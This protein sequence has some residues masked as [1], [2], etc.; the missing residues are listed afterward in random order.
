MRAQKFILAL[1]LIAATLGAP[2]EARSA[3]VGPPAETYITLNLHK[4]NIV[5]VLNTLAQRHRCNVVIGPGVSGEVSVNLHRVRLIEALRAV[6]S[7]GGCT[8]TEKGGVNFI[9]KASG[10]P[11]MPTDVRTIRLNYADV[12]EAAT[13]IS[14]ACGSEVK[15]HKQTRTLVLKDTPENLARAEQVARAVDTAPRQVL[16]EAKIIEVTLNDSLAFGVDWQKVFSWGATLATQ[17][18]SVPSSRASATGLFSTSAARGGAS[19]RPWTP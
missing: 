16:I 8:S 5:D 19:R 12:D 14:G 6:A 10:K 18:L 15:V 17:G 9:S 13:A 2:P 3:E 11:E 4:A 7:A 1:G